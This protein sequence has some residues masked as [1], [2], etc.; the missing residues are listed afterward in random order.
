M[1]RRDTLLGL[2]H[3]E[4]PSDYVPA[5]FFMH[6][7]PVYHQGQEAVDKHL[8][9]FRYTGMDLVKVQYEQTLPRSP[10]IRKPGDWARAPLYPNDF[11]DAPI[12]V[13]EGLVK[14]AKREALVI[15]TLYSPF[16]WAM[17]LAEDVNLA[18]HMKEDP[19]AVAKGLEIMTENVLNLVRGCK[20]V[21]VDGFYASSQGGE[22]FRFGGTEIF[23]KYIE[24]TDLAVWDEIRSCPFNILH[25]CD[26]R[27]EYDDLTP[28]LDYPGQLVNCSLKLGD[29]TLTPKEA[30]Q[31]FGRPFM[32]GMDRKGIIAT[33]SPEEIRQASERVLAEA[34]ERFI[35][36][37]DCTVPSDTPWEQLK[38]AID[39]AHQYRRQREPRVGQ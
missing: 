32:G 14:A 38:I 5:A 22:A 20:R 36:A 19:S 24:P 11:L 8:E 35:L 9:F 15:M 10:R 7:D 3:G 23:R 37:A 6:F 39:T 33:G 18:D 16:M 1:N 34:P 25:I 28:F 17:R 4:A 26:Y 30:S 31:M 13:V 21:G 29:R 27:G 12:R 2:I